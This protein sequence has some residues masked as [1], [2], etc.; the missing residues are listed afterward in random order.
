MREKDKPRKHRWVNVKSHDKTLFN[1]WETERNFLHQPSFQFLN[2]SLYP[3][4]SDVPSPSAPAVDWLADFTVLDSRQRVCHGLCPGA[5]PSPR[6]RGQPDSAGPA[7]GCQYLP[8]SEAAQV[9]LLSHRSASRASC[10]TGLSGAQTADTGK[11][12]STGPAR[13]TRHG[14]VLVTW[15]VF[16]RI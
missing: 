7:A 5:L 9:R 13:V 10:P 4:P 15:T 8:S 1:T 16:A 2:S 6:E 12:L 11:A 14:C 3:D